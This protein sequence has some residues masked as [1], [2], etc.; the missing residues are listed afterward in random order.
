MLPLI[1]LTSRCLRCVYYLLLPEREAHLRLLRPRPCR[2]GADV[3]DV[4]ADAVA[5]A[6]RSAMT[7]P[8]SLGLVHHRVRVARALMDEKCALNVQEGPT[9]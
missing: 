4:G 3:A 2:R 1:K 7:F 6:V 5:D 9:D 8:S